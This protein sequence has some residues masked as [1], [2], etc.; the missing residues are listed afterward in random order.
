MNTDSS[1]FYKEHIVKKKWENAVATC[2][3]EGANLFVPCSLSELDTI[4]INS[5]FIWLSYQDIY[6]PDHFTSIDG[7]HSIVLL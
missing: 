7:N 5:N 6:S 2:E 3:E 1:L 4:T